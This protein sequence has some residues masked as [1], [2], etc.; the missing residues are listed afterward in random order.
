MPVLQREYARD[1]T[2]FEKIKEEVFM[3]EELNGLIEKIKRDGVQAA[4]RKAGEI[5]SGARTRAEALVN[6]A[7]KDSEKIVSDAKEEAKKLK[8]SGQAALR[9][10]GRDMLIAL[11]KEIVSMLDTVAARSVGGALKGEELVRIIEDLIK[12][13]TDS[14]KKAMV[15]TVGKD[16]LDRLE[17][18]LLA[19]LSKE[20][21]KGV[22]LK[23]LDDIRGGF[24][25]S[26]DSGK[27]Y[28]DFT[29]EA[30]ANYIAYSLKP[31]LADILGKDA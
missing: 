2:G 29:E 16:D 1:K 17:K 4:E 12:A 11:K 5:E 18:A 31:R 28:Y 14:D 25:I 3:P 30:L 15:V 7:R 26:Y 22:T 21:K 24:L 27:S 20:M 8:E 10:A 6:K 19:D 9:Q 23:A 13:Q